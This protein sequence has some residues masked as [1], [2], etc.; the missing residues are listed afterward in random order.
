MDVFYD[1]PENIDE[2]EIL[3]KMM[4]LGHGPNRTKRFYVLFAYCTEVIDKETWITKYC[5]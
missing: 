3:R 5:H 4:S 1:N 2:R